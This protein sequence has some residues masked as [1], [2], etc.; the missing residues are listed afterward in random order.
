VIAAERRRA[1]ALPASELPAGASA[2][3]EAFGTTVAVFNVAGELFALGNR[4]P[5]HGGPLCR[6]RVSGALLPAEPYEY[7]W[8]REDRVLTCPWHGWQF[9]LESGQAL[10]D[11]LVR[12]P[13][14]DVRVEDG[15]IVLYEC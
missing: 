14:Y 6:G 7:R 13:R 10:F 2:G 12:V 8:G 9:D 5:H 11:P 1:V 4:C 3:V 15:Q